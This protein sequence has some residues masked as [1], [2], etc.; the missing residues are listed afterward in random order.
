MLNMYISNEEGTLRETDRISNGCWVQLIA[1][2]ELEMQEVSR[3]LE[4]PLEFF[5]GSTG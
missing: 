2:T 5:K 3:E 1:P 4:I